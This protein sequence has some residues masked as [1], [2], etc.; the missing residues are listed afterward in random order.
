[1]F[2]NYMVVGQGCRQAA[3]AMV[4]L[5]TVIPTY[6]TRASEDGGWLG[7]LLP[8]ATPTPSL[9]LPEDAPALPQS[10][11]E[12]APVQRPSLYEAPPA[13][14]PSLPESALFSV[15]RDRRLKTPLP[16]HHYYLKP[17]LPPPSLPV[18]RPCPIAIDA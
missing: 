3:M 9:S 7:V 6:G 2:S 1:M 16:Q 8:E 15:L 13:P 12:A 17:P 11:P 14:P 5:Q 10:L 18:S 4:R